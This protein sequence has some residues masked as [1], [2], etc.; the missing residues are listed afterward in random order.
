MI[1]QIK[2]R[3]ERFSTRFRNCR[4]NLL[5]VCTGHCDMCKLFCVLTD[6]TVQVLMSFVRPRT[7]GLCL[8]SSEFPERTILTVCCLFFLFLQNYICA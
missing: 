6:C 8:M 2:L 4:F 3:S 5:Q 7:V 1:F